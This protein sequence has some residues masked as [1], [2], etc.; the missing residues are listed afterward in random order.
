MLKSLLSGERFSVV[1]RISGDEKEA[2]A[3]AR[4]ICLEQTVEFPEELIPQ[5]AIRD[6]IVGQ[7]E[8]FEGYDGH[9]FKAVISYAVEITSYE[10]TQFLNVVFGNISM[11]P[12]IRVERLELPKSLLK[13][14]KGP[15][16]GREGLRRW[17][18]ITKR[19]LLSA[20]LKPMG[21]SSKELGDM[22]YKLALGGIDII[23]DDHSLANQCFSPFEERIRYCAEAVEKANNETGLKSIYVANVT[24]PADKIVERAK[25]AKAA[26]VKGIMVLPGLIGF[27]GMRRLADDDSI[28]LPILSHP[29]F[30]GSFVTHMNG[31]SHHA[32]F[33]QIAR[34]AGADV[35]IHPNFRGRFTFSREECQDILRE[36]SIQ[37]EHLKT[38][39]PC[40]GG[41]VNLD[42]IPDMIDVYGHDVVF[43]IGG[44]L[45]K[46]GPDLIDN[47]KYFKSIVDK[48]E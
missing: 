11:I 39:F 33:G 28:A 22:A 2:Y 46:R 1:Y 18:G 24:G 16:F 12:G 44:G 6:Y 29:A 4:D 8:S 35:S 38:N 41:G 13:F 14:L 30:Q 31:I 17:L 32:L 3:K 47:A 25:S 7:I 9:S 26:G 10:L 36:T 27:D 48:F 40:P 23:K 45:F 5:G 37:M 21:L 43:L 15:R 20:V 42:A 19:P 34:L